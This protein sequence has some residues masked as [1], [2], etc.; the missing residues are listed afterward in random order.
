MKAPQ[1]I[2]DIEKALKLLP[3]DVPL[4]HR[5]M[6]PAPRHSRRPLD[7]PGRV[8]VGGVLLL[9]Y[10][11]DDELHLILTQRKDDLQSHAGQVSF[12]G[13]RK[14]A[15]ETLM[16]T[17]LRETHEEIG[18]NPQM[19]SVL[20]ELSPIYIFPSDF[21]VHPFVA[22]YSNGKQPDFV[23]N[24]SEVAEIIEVPLKHLLDPMNRQEEMWKIQGYELLVPFFSVKGYKVWGATAM[25]LSEFLERMRTISSSS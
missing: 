6:S 17:A 24:K 11:R 23:P 14:E 12:P 21:E 16:A 1:T 19:V 15:S 22:W 9:L 5:K 20:G 4:A 10:C 8:R 7:K 2:D 13:G 18:I 3:F 25:M